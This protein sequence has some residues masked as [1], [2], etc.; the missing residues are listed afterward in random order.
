M[1]QFMGLSQLEQDYFITLVSFDR[2]G[3]EDYKSYIKLKLDLVRQK[4]QDIKNR[5]GPDNE[6]SLEDQALFYSS[7][8]YS[9]IRL[10]TSFPSCREVQDISEQLKLPRSQVADIVDFLV[11]RGLSLRGKEG[12]QLGPTVTH[13][14]NESR[15]TKGHQSEWRLKAIDNLSERKPTD[16]HYT[17][18]MAL[19][20][21]VALEIR[22]ELIKLIEES[23][24][25]VK[26]SSSEK[27]NCMNLDWFS[28]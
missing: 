2:A 13:L 23:I 8:K 5:V 6:L 15:F 17:G 26:P 19:S 9:A 24:K 27:L 3:T 10:L 11:S 12:L 20:E 14:G 25:K 7:W 22:E 21:S 18:L 16:L 1:A 4:S 28:I